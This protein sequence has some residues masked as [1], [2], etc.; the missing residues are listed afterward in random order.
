MSFLP[1]LSAI[2]I[3]TTFPNTKNEKRILVNSKAYFM[4]TS[5]K[6]IGMLKI[7]KPIAPHA[8]NVKAQNIHIAKGFL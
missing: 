5:C 3:Q 8:L 1:T 2:N 6:N 4:P 7:Y